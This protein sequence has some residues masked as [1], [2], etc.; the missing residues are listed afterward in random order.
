MNDSPGSSPPWLGSFI[1]PGP[2]SKASKRYVAS[3]MVW[4]GIYVAL[5]VLI[6][7]VIDIHALPLWAQVGAAILPA[8]TIGGVIHEL[9]RY[10]TTE[11]DEFQRMLMT[12]AVLLA[13]GVTFFVATVWG[14]LEFYVRAPHFPTGLIMALFWGAFGFTNTWVRR[15]YR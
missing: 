8:L 9:L 7:W 4:M 5:V 13:M 1:C 11:P 2:V 3:I 10:L 14:F 6:S 12:R 15:R